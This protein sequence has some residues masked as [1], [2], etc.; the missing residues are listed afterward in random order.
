LRPRLNISA[1]MWLESARGIS[2][3]ERLTRA[4]RVIALRSIFVGDTNDKDEA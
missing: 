1:R 4:V 3:R 2:S